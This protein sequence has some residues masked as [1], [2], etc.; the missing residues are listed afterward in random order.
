MLEASTHKYLREFLKKHP[1]NWK[2]IYAFGRLIANFLRKRKNLLVNSEIFHTNEWYAGVLIA[3]FLNQENAKFIISS[4]KIKLLIN[5][6]LP[7]FKELGFNFLVKKNQIIFSKHKILLLTLDELIKNH[8]NLRVQ[9][10]NLIF[11]ESESIQRDINKKLKIYLNKKDWYYLAN[12][13]PHK[14]CE[15]INVYNDLKKKF[16]LKASPNQKYISIN[17]DEINFLKTIFLK[18]SFYKDKF[19]RLKRGIESNWALWVEL[20]HDKFEWSLQAQPIEGIYEIKELL[21][22]NNIIFLSS[23]RKDNFLQKYF[24]KYDIIFNSVIHLN[25]FFKEQHISI[26]VPSRLLLPNNP[27]FIKS[28]IDKC[29]KFSLLSKGRT[30]FLSNQINFKI[31]LA[32]KLASLF[33]QRILLENHPFLDNHIVCSSFDWW[34]SNIHLISPPEHIIIPFLPLPSMGKPINQITI[35]YINSNSND[36]FREFMFPEAFNKIDQAISP[37]RQN[38]GKLIFLDGRINNRKWGQDLLEMIQPH[39]EINY[40]FPFD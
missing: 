27:L 10:Q 38:A 18:F 32:T 5:V 34:I 23:F 16:F 37:L 29:I 7:L 17:S 8:T 30:I 25:S 33:G 1:S 28:T 2:H 22:E 9:N 11:A 24:K 13:L 39:K 31:N 21:I 40:M 36:W 19:S 6:Y 15:L 26:Y 12:K 4:E 35:S 20:D 14:N 3:L